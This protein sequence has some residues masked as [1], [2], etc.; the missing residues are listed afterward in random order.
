MLCFISL[1][2]AVLLSV[3]ADDPEVTVTRLQN[4]PNRLFYFEDTPV[5]LVHTCDADPPGHLDA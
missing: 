1:L 3:R 5:S 2:F 4:L